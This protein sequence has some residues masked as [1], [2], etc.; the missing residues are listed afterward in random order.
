M[1][2][3]GAQE[4]ATGSGVPPTPIFISSCEQLEGSVLTIDAGSVK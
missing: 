3:V 4:V 1:G 2:W